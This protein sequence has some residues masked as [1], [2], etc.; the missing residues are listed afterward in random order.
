MGSSLG[1]V[2]VEEPLQAFPLKLQIAREF[3]GRDWR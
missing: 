1:L 3:V 2:T